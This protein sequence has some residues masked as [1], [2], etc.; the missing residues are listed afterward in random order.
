MNNP[1]NKP[2]GLCGDLADYEFKQEGFWICDVCWSVI[3]EDYAEA[4]ELMTAEEAAEDAAESRQ[5]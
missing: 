2:C 3:G 1:N 5:P 4:H